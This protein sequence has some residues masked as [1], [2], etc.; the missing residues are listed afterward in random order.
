MDQG[1]LGDQ[2]REVIEDQL[3]IE[4]LRQQAL[5]Q[6]ANMDSITTK[7]VAAH[8][9][10][11]LATVYAWIGRGWLEIIHPHR[12]HEQYRVSIASFNYL[13]AQFDT[14]RPKLKKFIPRVLYGRG[15]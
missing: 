7:D 10:V 14:L 13:D 2:A 4:D 8:F 11:S 9:D 1:T 6:Q 5:E 12:K 3:R 15:R